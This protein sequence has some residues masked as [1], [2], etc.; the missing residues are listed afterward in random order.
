MFNVSLMSL[1]EM[2]KDLGWITILVPLE[3]FQFGIELGLE[4][5]PGVMQVFRL[6]PKLLH[7]LTQ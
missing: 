6:N 5:Q 1:G 2:V 4:S 3:A 7:N